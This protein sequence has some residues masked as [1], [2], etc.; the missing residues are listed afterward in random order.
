MDEEKLREA[1]A[2]FDT[3]GSGLIDSAELKAALR[4]AYIDCGEEISDEDIDQLADV[5]Q[6]E[7]LFNYFV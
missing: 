7:C 5:R 3:D 2:R 6:R 4:A 1:F